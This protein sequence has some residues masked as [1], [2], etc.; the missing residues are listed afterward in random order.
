M[1]VDH[2]QRYGLV[3][4]DLRGFGDT[5]SAQAA[6]AVAGTAPSTSVWRSILVGVATGTGVYLASRLVDHLFGLNRR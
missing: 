5:G 6:A 2:S 4:G 3:A 1:I